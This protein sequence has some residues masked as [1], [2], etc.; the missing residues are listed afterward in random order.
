LPRMSADRDLAG[1]CGME[2]G[3]LTN[4]RTICHEQRI[5]M[6]GSIVFKTTVN[7]AALLPVHYFASQTRLGQPQRMPQTLNACICYP[8]Y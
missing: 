2:N 4:V 7:H 1:R 6:L 5:G 8:R 3:P